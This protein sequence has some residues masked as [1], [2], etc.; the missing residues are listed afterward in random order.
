MHQQFSGSGKLLGQWLFWLFS[1]FS[2][3]S[4]KNGLKVKKGVRK[5]KNDD[6]KTGITQVLIALQQKF[7]HQHWAQKLTNTINFGYVPFLLKYKIFKDVQKL[8]LFCKRLPL[9][10]MSPKL[11]HIWERHGKITPKRATHGCCIT[12]KRFE[13]L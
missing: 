11:C 3:D 2:K 1:F 4:A 12:T 9:V 13:N 6:T 8:Y 10:K 5:I 7:F